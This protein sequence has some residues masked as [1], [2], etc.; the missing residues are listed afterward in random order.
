[1]HD[2]NM[3]I[4]VMGVTGSGK[5][6]VAEALAKRLGFVEE[7]ADLYHSATNVT[8]MQSGTPLTDED[9]LPWLHIVADLIDNH[10]ASNHPVVVACSALKRAYRDILIQGRRDVRLVY[11]KGTRDVIAARIAHRKGHFMPPSLLD[12]QFKALEEP[13]PD[14]HA[15]IVDIDAPVDAIVNEIIRQLHLPNHAETKT[16]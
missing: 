7:D 12:S 14:E 11:L 15:V 8:K 4:I 3:A 2:K 10:I 9:R 6:T 16:A 5:S 13:A 1:M